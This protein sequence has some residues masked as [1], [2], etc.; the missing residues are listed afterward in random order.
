MSVRFRRRVSLFPGVRLNVGKRGVSLSTGV[1]GASLTLGKTG[2][3]SNLGLP[4][5]GL[6]VREKIS[7]GA[8][9]ARS[10]TSSPSGTTV[11]QSTLR[12]N[13]DGSLDFLDAN[14]APLPENQVR[15][16]KR[17]K[18]EQI[19]E[20]LAQQCAQV[21]AQIEA[22]ETLHWN[23]PP[24]NRTPFYRPV[25][26]AALEPVPPQP[27]SLGI[28]GKLFKRVRMKIEQDNAVAHA[29]YILRREAWQTAKS[30]HEAEEQ[31]KQE[32]IETR[33]RSDPQAMDELLETALQAIEWPRETHVTFEVSADMTQ[34]WVDVD[35]PEIEDLP[36]KTASLPSRGWRITLKPLTETKH[37]QLYMN[38]VHGVGFR[39]IGEVFATLPTVTAVV[40]SAYSQRPDKTTG[41][42]QDEYLYSVRVM[43]ESWSRINFRNLPA[44]DVVAAF[45]N[46]ETRRKVTKT[47]IFA[48]IDPIHS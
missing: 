30:A 29:D 32:A 13:E 4:G 41:E 31:C 24:P 45:D 12:L 2:L 27:I 42:I 48:P 21:N 37:R 9:K 17:Q 38:H 47:G 39:L 18:G 14:E 3:Y 6:S 36:N 22:L 25:P 46:F 34:V 35:L 15:L 40:L 44:I 20:F 7:G 43:R 8:S 16:I 23:T 11:V 33:L 1:R 19:R 10:A 26:Y 5:S 28:L